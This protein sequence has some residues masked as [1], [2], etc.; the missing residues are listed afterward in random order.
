MP[1]EEYTP[2][3]ALRPQRIPGIESADLLGALESAGLKCTSPAVLRRGLSWTCSAQTTRGDYMVTLYGD[4]TDS[5]RQVSATVSQ[6]DG[7]ASDMLAV[8]FLANLA[9]VPYQ[10]SEP[11]RARQWVSANIGP[12]GTLAIGGVHFEL[13]GAPGT[14]TLDMVVPDVRR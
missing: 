12:G 2:S 13:S 11:Q 1:V 3:P 8:M 10:G 9:G 4:R 7:S 6:S 5:I 14:R